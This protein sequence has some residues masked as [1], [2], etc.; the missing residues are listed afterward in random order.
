MNR[1]QHLTH[2][3]HV[4][5][6]NAYTDS[7]LQT[8]EMSVIKPLIDQFQSEKEAV[9][10][11]FQRDLNDLRTQTQSLLKA[12]MT[13]G[14]PIVCSVNSKGILV[15]PTEG[16]YSIELTCD[17][18]KIEFEELGNFVILIRQT[19]NFQLSATRMLIPNS[20][21]N[22]RYSSLFADKINS[23]P[24]GQTL[25]LRVYRQDSCCLIDA[26]IYS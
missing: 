3:S 10:L 11:E 12:E 9:R 24:F 8:L 21:V 13:T 1:L 16:T 5:E 6:S 17:L 22:Q 20:Q 15:L 25:E 7:K 2:Q 26:V 14:R 23:I 18:L 4:T 19:R